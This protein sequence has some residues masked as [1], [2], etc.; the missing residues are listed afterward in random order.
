[1]YK[2]FLKAFYNRTNKKKYDSQIQQYNIYYRN[3]IVIKNVIVVVK[4]SRENKKLLVMKNI[5]K[6]AIAEVT[7]VLSTIDLK[8]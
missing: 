5:D 8:K 7:K 6:T 2:Y 3:T 4:K 1:M